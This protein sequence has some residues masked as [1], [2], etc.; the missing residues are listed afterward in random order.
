MNKYGFDNRG[1]RTGTGRELE[2][3]GHY[4]VFEKEIPSEY[5]VAEVI[6]GFNTGGKLIWEQNFRV[7]TK[8][9]PLESVE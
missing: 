1:F 5:H 3:I 7:D 8:H 9:E 2:P 6:V 4:R